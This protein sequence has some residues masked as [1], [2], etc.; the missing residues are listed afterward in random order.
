MTYLQYQRS[1]SRCTKKK[2]LVKSFAERNSQARI[3]VHEPSNIFPPLTPAVSPA[4]TEP[5]IK[6]PLSIGGG[7]DFHDFVF[8]TWPFM[9]DSIWEEADR[10]DAEEHQKELD[11]RRR[12]EDECLASDKSYPELSKTYTSATQEEMD[13]CKE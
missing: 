6:N 1:G 13:E 12:K 8:N 11:E 7:A 2:R 5:A 10:R 4:G 3:P 9:F